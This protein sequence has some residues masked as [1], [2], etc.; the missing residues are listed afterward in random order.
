MLKQQEFLVLRLKFIFH[1]CAFVV[2]LIIKYKI[3]TVK[4]ARKLINNIS[5]QLYFE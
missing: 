3:N 2:L 1:L 5:T 4:V